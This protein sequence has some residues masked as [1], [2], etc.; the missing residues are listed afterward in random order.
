MAKFHNPLDKK[1]KKASGKGKVTRTTTNT[2][3]RKAVS[4]AVTAENKSRLGFGFLAIVVCFTI[5]IFRLAFWQ[6]IKADDLNAKAA[7]MQKIDTELDPVRGN[8]Y[9]RNKKVLAQTVT[10][11]ELYGYSLNLYKKKG[12]DS[13]TK[14]K[15]LRDLSKLSG[16]SR[17]EMKKK[18]SGKDNL[19][20]LAK[21]LDQSQ[22]N[23]AQKE[24]GDDIVVKTKVTRSYPNGTFASTLLGSVDSKNTGLNGLEYQYNEKLAGIKGR[25]VRTTDIYGNALSVGS[26]KYYSPQNGDSLVTSIDEV[27]QHYVEDAIADTGA[28]S[29]TCIVMDPRTGDILAM[30]S[31]PSYDPNNPYTPSGDEAKKFKSLS[32]KEKSAYL[33]RMWTNPAVSGLYE[34]GST[35]KLITSSS[36]IESGTTTDS[37]RYSC[38]GY[39]NVDGTKLNC[40]SPVPHGTQNITEAVGNSCNPALARVALDMGKINFYKYI[41]IFGFTQKTRVDLPGEAD[42]IIKNKNNVSNV[43]LATMGY[44]HGI[45]ISPIQLM[46]AINSLGNDGIMMQPKVVKEIIGPDGKVKKVIKNRRLRQTISKS[47]ADKMRSIMEYYVSDGGGTSAYLAGYRVGGKTG[48]ANIAENSGYSEQTIASFIAMAPMDN[49]QVSI[50]VMVTRPKKSR[51]GAANAGPIV[52]KILE[53]T[54]VYKGIERKYSKSEK[55]AIAKAEI[56]VPDVTGLNSSEAISKITAAGLKAKKM[57]EGTGDS[58]VVIDQYPKKGDK[59]AKGGTVYIYSE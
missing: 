17:K 31:T 34:P 12:L 46:T 56:S 5:L 58:F 20:L 40:W 43:D 1:N 26:S 41:D 55:S 10:K 47:T 4:T 25:V 16:D 6:V 49:P 2:A 27:I 36:A 3:N 19:V 33:S 18:L 28:E 15:N 39:I 32:T 37:S 50:L 23:K 11:Y 7:E 38:P 29:I 22:V 44:G 35:F 54:L 8:I 57:P 42:P 48:T 30:A 45:A 53:K 24:W 59:I 9:D 21:G 13:A 51:Y 52:K 14:E